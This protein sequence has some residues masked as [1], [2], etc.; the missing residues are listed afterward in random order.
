[1]VDDLSRN[2]NVLLQLDYERTKTLDVMNVTDVG[3][4]ALGE[5]DDRIDDFRDDTRA[6]EVLGLVVVLLK[7]LLDEKQDSLVCKKFLIF[8]QHGI[9]LSMIRGQFLCHEELDGL[10]QQ[11]VL[12]ELVGAHFGPSARSIQVDLVEKAGGKT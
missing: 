4:N 3:H 9:L 10:P 5:S 11:R 8:G 1:M 6:F 7:H 12:V 2:G